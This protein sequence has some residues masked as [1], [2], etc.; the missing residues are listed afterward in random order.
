M[1]EFLE[2]R[3]RALG[4]EVS[5]AQVDLAIEALASRWESVEAEEGIDA[6]FEKRAPGWAV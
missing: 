1:V 5:K 4:G 3:L 6:F 2:Q